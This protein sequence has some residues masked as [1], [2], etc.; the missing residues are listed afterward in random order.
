[1]DKRIIISVFIA[2]IA[3]F[4]QLIIRPWVYAQE[5]S[6]IIDSLVGAFPSFASG[7]GLPLLI[8]ALTK[9]QHTLSACIGIGVGLL[10]REIFSYGSKENVFGTTFDYWDIV[11]TILGI[12]GAYFLN[13]KFRPKE[14]V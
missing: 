3:G 6:T 8:I 4:V 1:M 9:W 12:I 5:F 14:M 13:Q 11:A 10:L 2:I 7:L